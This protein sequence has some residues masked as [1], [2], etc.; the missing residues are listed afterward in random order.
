MVIRSLDAIVRR[1]S[2]RLT[3]CGLAAAICVFAGGIAAPGQPRTMTQGNNSLAV[4][5]GFWEHERCQVVERDGTRTGSRSVFSFFE[6]E[7]GIAYT[8]YADEDCRIKVLT[9]VLSGV[10]ESSGPSGRLPDATDV[11]FR[12]SRKALTVYDLRLLDTLNR[13][14]CGKRRWRLGVEQDVTSTGCLWIESVAAC[15]QEY[16][17][18]NIDDGRLFLGERPAAGSNMCAASR[19]PERLRTV[20]LVRR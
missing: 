17:L 15:P 9:A 3:A 20:P 4:L 2:V 13:D 16:D 18:V 10:Y 12:F 11:T 6:R 7:W 8:Q 1:P 19:R 14:A 5:A